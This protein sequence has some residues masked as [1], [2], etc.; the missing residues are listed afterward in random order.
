VHT[1]SSR[2]VEAAQG[3]RLGGSDGWITFIDG[4]DATTV[5]WAELHDD[6]LAM[7]A[8]LQANG[9][10]A[11]DHVAILGPTSRALVTAVQAIW[12][13]G[14]CVVMLPL[15]MRM[16][17]IEAF[18]AQTRDRIAQAD[19]RLVL[20]DPQFRE[21]I[22]P[23]DGD[24]PMVGLDELATDATDFIRPDD[25]PDALAILQFTSGS[26]SDPKGV[27]LP[28]RQ[29]CH[30]LDGAAAAADLRQGDVLVSWLPLYH[31]MGLIGLLTIPMTTGLNLVLGAPQDFLAKPVRWMQWISTYGGT[32]TA[33]PNFAYVLATRALRRAD[34]LDLSKMR[35]ALNGA[36]PVDADSFREFATEAARFGF[37]DHALYPAF[38]MAEVCIAGVFPEPGSGLSTDVVDGRVLET[39][40]Y[41]A[42]T[43]RDA[44]HAKELAVLGTAIPGLQIRIVD[45]SSGLVCRIR[46]VGELQIS[47]TSLTTG[48]YQRPDATAESIVDGWLRTGDLAYLTEDG[49][50]V[51]CGRIK[52]VV[53]IGGRNIYPQ[54]IEKVVGGLDGVRTGNVIAFGQEGR[55]R[56]QHVVVVAETKLDD[57]AALAKSISAAVTQHIGVPP[58]HVV[59]VDAGTVPK[60]SSG[61]L[62]RSACRRMFE[63]GEL[64][65]KNG[66]IDL[67]PASQS[68]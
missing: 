53:I 32:C 28:H 31:D 4:D 52:D 62:Q 13:S 60:T 68:C 50:M 23:V 26:T 20:I 58:R 27:M 67:R 44:R 19:S 24:V 5:P 21:F 9:V 56:K 40:R 48:Y 66:A 46:E 64:V 55:N 35:T 30:N 49:G 42:T 15:P 16:A 47:G 39:E 1:L 33:G 25:D 54:D 8:G 6:A 10:R 36:E 37:P 12:L 51:M 43:T 61:K 22:T 29:I 17:S 11:G 57:T 34:G 65:A 7:A 63:T 3:R 18:I 59:L 41:A 14:G 2:I 38:G 45:P